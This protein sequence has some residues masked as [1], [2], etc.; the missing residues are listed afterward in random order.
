MLN[1]VLLKFTGRL[2]KV[3]PSMML[4]VNINYCPGMGV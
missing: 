4:E 1:I 3:K 2:Q